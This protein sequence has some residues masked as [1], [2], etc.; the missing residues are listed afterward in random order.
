MDIAI[1]G[2]SFDPPHIGHEAIVKESLS[3]LDIDKLI[4]VPTFLNPFKSNSHFDSSTRLHLIRKLFKKFDKVEVS[5]YESAS[6]ISV[7]TIKTVIHLYT[8]YKP[9]NIYLIVGADNFGTIENWDNYELLN[10]LVKFVVITRKKHK[11]KEKNTPIYKIIELKF[12]IS[13]TKL[14]DNRNLK[15]VPKK[16][17]KEVKELWKKELKE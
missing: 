10:S 4:V 14:R 5:E 2:G 9:K 12:N 13:S 11:I 17:Y 1:F 15:Y 3:Q 6:G 16:I 8:K 7:P